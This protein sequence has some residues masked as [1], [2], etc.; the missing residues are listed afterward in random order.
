MFVR[1]FANI[2]AM[3]W[4]I[5]FYS[6]RVRNCSRRLKDYLDLWVLL[7]RE[8]LNADT[9][10]KA[11]AA[12]FIRRGT[13]LPATLPVGLTDEFA[14]GASRQAMGHAFLKKNGITITALS[15]VVS[16]LRAILEPALVQATTFSTTESS[17]DIGQH[18]TS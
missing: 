3:N 6:E 10:A 2:A 1:L 15:G 5:H 13:P 17:A 7:D 11:I 14:T 9:L 12:T 4:A 8:S 16:K 18:D